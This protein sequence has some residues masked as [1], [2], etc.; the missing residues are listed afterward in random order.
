MEVSRVVIES[1]TP[2]VYTAC[3][4][5]LDTLNPAPPAT[6][7]VIR[8]REPDFSVFCVARDEGAVVFQGSVVDYVVNASGPVAS[9]AK[10]EVYRQLV[11]T[12]R[13]DRSVLLELVRVALEQ[14]RIR[15][16]A[17]RGHPAAGVM[18]YVWDEGVECWDSGKLVPHRT[19]G[20]VFLP[21]HAAEDVMEDLHAY[22]KPDT[23]ERYAALH[24]API[25]VYMLHGPPGAGKTALVHCLAS[26][27]G[28]N[29]AV[30]NFK[31]STRDKD[32]HHALRNLPP[33]TFLC[34]EDIDCCF[35]ARENRN[36]GVSFASV[37]AALD[38][39][40]DGSNGSALTV[41]MTSNTIEKLDEALRRRVDYA[42]EFGH[43]TKHQCWQM[44]SVF[45]PNHVGFEALWA[46]IK[47]FKF[48]MSVLQKFL[49]RTL[50]RKDPLACVDMFES[51]IACTYGLRGSHAHSMYC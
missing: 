29:L 11:L 12:T 39:S 46:R 47:H 31:P 44:F 9:D 3:V 4:A 42:L 38:G 14:H 20:T 15:T 1:N 48:T 22:L 26:E 32:V 41:F 37:L 51:L 50:H 33:R 24:I 13:N 7:H 6:V 28:H 16:T 30:L 25:R 43:A 21:P 27:T 17:P 36:H 2:F 23:L 18:R 40:F 35:D 49:V 34:I 8:P 45:H 5:Y 10:P 19:L